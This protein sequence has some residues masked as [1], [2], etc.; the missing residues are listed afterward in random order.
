ME[1]KKFSTKH[2]GFDVTEQEDPEIRTMGTIK[3]NAVDGKDVAIDFKSNPLGLVFKDITDLKQIIKQPRHAEF[4]S[5]NEVLLHLAIC[6]TVVIDK[7]KGVYNAAS[8]DE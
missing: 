6:H 5:L 1:F 2:A 8:P 3:I 4:E 7:I